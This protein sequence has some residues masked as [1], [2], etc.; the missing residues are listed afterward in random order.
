MRWVASLLVVPVL[1]VGCSLPLSRRVHE[2]DAGQPLRRQQGDLQVLPPGPKKGQSPQDVVQGFLGAQANPDDHHAIAREFLTT[3]AAATWQDDAEVQVYDPDS[4]RMRAQGGEG[5][6][7]VTVALIVSGQVRGDGSYLAQSAAHVTE[8]YS[9]TRVR[10]DWRLSQV[11]AGLR[12]TPA[13]RDRSYQASSVYYLAPKTGESP[14]H[15]VPD[16]VF[17]PVGPDPALALVQRLLRPPSQSL[18]G[19]VTSALPA[20]TALRS[21]AISGSGVVTVDLAAGLAEL[22]P[23]SR[24]SLSAQLVWTLR[25]L[26][27]TFS[28]LRLLSGGV[29]L[30]VPT[31]GPVQDAGSWNTYDPEGLGP[32]P[33]YYFVTAR[34]LRASVTLPSGPATAGE[35][36]DRGSV[37]V[38]SVAVTPDR[39]QVALL[40]G[41][42]PGRVTV[43]TGPLRG[44]VYAEGPTVR[45]LTSPTWGSGQYGLWMLEGGRRVVLLPRGSKALVAVPVVLQPAGPLQALALSRDGARVA[46]VIGGVLYV[47]RV[48]VVE[49]RPR[50][51]GLTLVLPGLTRA[52]C[53]AWSSGTELAVL[54]QLAR[55][56]QV[57][58]VAVDG[59]SVTTLNSSGLTP[60]SLAAS[61]AGLVVGS[62]SA[63]Y[64]ASGR[65]FVRVQTGDLPVFPG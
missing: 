34:R 59:S 56:N 25:D 47:G 7:T 24:Q 51:A 58:L 65:G 1:A 13:D 16:E 6:P 36:G 11:P 41:R 29:P 49:G 12:L 3:A 10:G 4:L 40:T 53:V 57:L 20:G 9:A 48:E 31:V 38:D 55:P 44:P 50:V 22:P 46:L 15:V 14:P 37:P 5:S 21:V 23:A 45:D 32:N 35:A 63:L 64:Q 30:P 19:T 62:R 33:P 43:R 61:S 42:A 28:G 60:V 52:T 54:G 8:Q 2:V 27:P 39:T 26:G 17:V 18:A